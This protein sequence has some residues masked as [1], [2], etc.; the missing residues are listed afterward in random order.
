[1]NIAYFSPIPFNFLMQRPQ[2]LAIEL[3]KQHNVYFIEPT[4][5]A[6]RWIL[7]RGNSPRYSIQDYSEALR[8]VKLN[9]LFA[10]PWIINP[11]DITG[12]STM[13]E[14]SQFKKFIPEIDIVWVGHCGWY[15]LVKN[16][17]YKHLVYDK[18]DDNALLARN[19]VRSRQL[20]KSDCK[21]LLESDCVFTTAKKFYDDTLLVNKNVYLVPNAVNSNFSSSVCTEKYGHKRV[22]GYV[23]MIDNWFDTQAICTIVEASEDHEVVLVGPNNIPEIKHE[24]V[25]Y[26]GRVSKD[27]VS[28]MINSFDVCLYPFKAGP[29]LDTINPVKIYE[30]LA[31]NKPVIAIENKEISVFGSLIYLYRS[32]SELTQIC[33]QSIPSPFQ[34]ETERLAFIGGNNWEHRGEQTLSILELL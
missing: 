23:G 33:K 9:G 28:E 12:I 10:A 17:K 16:L 30:Y 22:F 20:A 13:W 26:L 1:M 25:K 34:T 5:S 8:I 2:Y 24:R 14:R 4:D 21:L 19:S 18:M 15:P 31:A 7:G 32:Y 6:A 11:Y 29:L 3:S 27:E